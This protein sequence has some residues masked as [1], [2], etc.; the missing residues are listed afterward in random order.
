[1]PQAGVLQR[2][3]LFIQTTYQ[4]KKEEKNESIRGSYLVSTYQEGPVGILQELAGVL[5]QL[6]L[7]KDLIIV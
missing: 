7:M 1:M 6:V 3:H 4:V 5:K 2:N